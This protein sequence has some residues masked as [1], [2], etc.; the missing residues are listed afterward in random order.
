MS[1]MN[2]IHCLL[3]VD[4][5]FQRKHTSSSNSSVMLNHSEFVKWIKAFMTNM[6]SCNPSQSLVMRLKYKPFVMELHRVELNWIE[7]SWMIFKIVLKKN[8]CQ[9]L[10]HI[11]PVINLKESSHCMT[12]NSIF[13]RNCYAMLWKRVMMNYH[14]YMVCFNG[15]SAVRS[16]IAV[17]TRYI[18]CL[19]SLLSLHLLDDTLALA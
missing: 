18:W 14:N 3:N 5:H 4:K 15:V 12:S 19:C 8:H 2:T 16:K 9:Y 1:S 11:L 6:L 13:H 7:W 17:R 10:I